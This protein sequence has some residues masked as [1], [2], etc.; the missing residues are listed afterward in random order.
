M[1]EEMANELRHIADLADAATP[2]PWAADPPN[3]KLGQ[4]AEIVG[5]GISAAGDEVGACYLDADAAFIA[6]ARSVNY[7]ALAAVVKAARDV[8]GEDDMI[9]HVEA[10]DDPGEDA[11]WAY[12]RRTAAIDRLR[13]ALVEDPE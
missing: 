7:R 6:A 8:V 1:R 9:A 10:H 11:D 5:P 3:T 13:A 2:G 12:E 4:P